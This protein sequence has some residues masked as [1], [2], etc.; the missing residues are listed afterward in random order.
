[1]QIKTLKKCRSGYCVNNCKV[2]L[3]QWVITNSLFRSGNLSSVE[4]AASQLREDYFRW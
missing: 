4:S 1:M 2:A 3:M